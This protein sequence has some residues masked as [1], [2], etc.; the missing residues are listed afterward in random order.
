MIPKIN[1]QVTNF[2]KLVDYVDAYQ[3]ANL[4]EFQTSKIDSCNQLKQFSTEHS[5]I[6]ITK[7]TNT[8]SWP[9]LFKQTLSIYK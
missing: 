4:E 5:L 1:L 8:E 7:F 9:Q 2:S 6:G 3:P